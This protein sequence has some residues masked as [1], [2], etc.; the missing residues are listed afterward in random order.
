ME[1]RDRAQ[2]VAPLL[3]TGGCVSLAVVRLARPDLTIDTITLV[4]IAIA[5]I[6]WLGHI[7][8]SFELPG[9]PKVTYHKLEQRIASQ[10]QKIAQAQGAARSAEAQAGTL[11]SSITANPP[12][13]DRRQDERASPQSAVAN[14][15]A[16]YDEIRRTQQAGSGRTAAMTDIVAR[17]LPLAGGGDVDIAHGLTGE[18]GERLAA[19]IALFAK[20]DPAHLDALVRS[21]ST[22]EPGNA[23][24][25]QA[26]PFEQYWG[27]KAVRKTLESMDPRDVAPV[28]RDRLIALRDQIDP[29]TD[30]Y[31]EASQLL[32]VFE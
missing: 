18:G 24:R 7:I 6:P 3:I 13:P 28:T 8:E 26:Q 10:D 23:R 20:P 1:N 11:L 15:I 9:G 25:F 16:A 5:A 29:S 32:K 31:F 19:Y 27:I 4:L 17:M 14:L 22:L 21:V 12:H 2:R 30:R